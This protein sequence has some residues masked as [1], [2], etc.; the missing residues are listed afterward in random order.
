MTE[1]LDALVALIEWRLFFF[2]L[3]SAVLSVLQVA[4][5]LSFFGILVLFMEPAAVVPIA[6]IFFLAM[7]LTK[8]RLFRASIDWALVRRLT[9]ASVPGVLIGS[10]LLAYLPN[11]AVRRVV[12]ALVIVMLACEI[13]KIKLFDLDVSPRTLNGV[14]FGYGLMSG[15][16]G[17]GSIVRTPLLLK[18]KLSKEA[19]I[20]TAAAASLVSNV[21]KVGSYSATGLLTSYVLVNGILSIVIGIIGT[22]IGKALVDKID[23]RRFFTIVRLALLASAFIGL[24]S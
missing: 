21:L 3:L 24:F 7:N 17:S 10:L 12:C 13:L 8:M 9:V 11:D 6:T 15:F 16:L 19:F 22:H 14:G 5:L 23:E 1:S 20:A 18:L 2:V 4:S